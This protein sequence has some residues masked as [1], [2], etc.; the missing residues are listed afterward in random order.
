MEKTTNLNLQVDTAVKERAEKIFS[1]LGLPI[2]TAVNLFLNQVS[3]KGGLPFEVTLPPA[4]PSINADLMT[5]EELRQKL[6]KGFDDAAAGRC[7]PA[8]EAFVEFMESHGYE[9]L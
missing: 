3:L 1:Q 2:S 4:P 7:R 8:K 9:P 5:D 6:Q